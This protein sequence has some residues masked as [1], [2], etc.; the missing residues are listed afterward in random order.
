MKRLVM[1]LVV[2][3]VATTLSAGGGK[4][5]DV[6]KK[7][8]AKAVELTGTVV[9]ADGDCEKATFKVADSD[10]T[11]DVCHKSKAALKTLGGEG[12]VVKVK[13]KLISCDESEGTELMIE[14]AQRI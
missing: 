10:T 5:C 7:A 11:Y 2:V 3:F 8:S 4:H 13:G 12:K 9:C 6:S 1:V 14:S